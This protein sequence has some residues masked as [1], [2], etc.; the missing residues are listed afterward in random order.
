MQ[1]QPQ[2]AMKLA[3]WGALPEDADGELVDG[4]VV[5]EELASYLH[6]TVVAFL[7]ELFRA[8][9]REHGARVAASS[10]RFAVTPS[11]GRKP[12]LSVFLE[13]SARPPARGLIQ[14]PP[15][16]AIEVVSASPADQRRDRVEK[17]HDYATFGVRF[18][19]LL[20]PEARTLEILE[21]GADARYVV[22]AAASAGKIDPVPG[23]DAL[24]LDLDALWAELD[25]VIAEGGTD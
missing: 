7:V 10:A 14:V 5:E 19:W 4:L 3:E 6:E 24:A 12:D 11:R 21:R 8:W 13:G 18:Y 15:T 20:D 9:G 1:L 22:V 23:C 16:I 25:E 2:R 17:L